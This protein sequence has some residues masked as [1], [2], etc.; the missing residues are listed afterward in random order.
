VKVLLNLMNRQVA[1]SLGLDNIGGDW[2]SLG[3]MS[4]PAWAVNSLPAN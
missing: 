1:V 3:S 4:A 2:V